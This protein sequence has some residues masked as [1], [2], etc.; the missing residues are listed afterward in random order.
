MNSEHSHVIPGSRYRH[1]KGGEYTVV[2]CAHLET[3]PTEVYVV[4]RMEYA[5]Q[6]F[7]LGTVWIRPFADFTATVSV[8]GKNILRFTQVIH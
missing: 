4:Y 6:D 2:A 3:N 8:D 5:T 7:P 1:Y